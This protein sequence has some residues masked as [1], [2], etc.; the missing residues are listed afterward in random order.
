[1]K[2]EYR[3]QKTAFFGTNV[4]FRSLSSFTRP[5]KQTVDVAFFEMA[6]F[7]NEHDDFGPDVKKNALF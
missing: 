1:M 3:E 2:G 7:E 5:Y 4:L 6:K